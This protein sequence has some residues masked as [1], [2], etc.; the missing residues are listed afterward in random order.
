MTTLRDEPEKQ[1]IDLRTRLLEF[2]ARYYSANVMRLVLLGRESLDDLQALAI[3]FF[4]AIENKAVDPPQH[5]KDPFTPAELGKRLDVVPVKESRSIELS[6][7][8]PSIRDKYRTSPQSILSHLLGHEGPGSILSLLKARGWA[9]GLSAGPS[10]AQEAFCI[11]SVSVDCTDE[12]IANSEGVISVVYQYLARLKAE[13]VQPW[14]FEEC[15]DIAAMNF[16]FKSKSKP[17][18]YTTAIATNMQALPAD[19]TLAGYALFFDFSIED[20]NALSSA[21]TPENML[22]TVVSKACEG[23][24]DQEEQWY[25]TKYKLADLSAELQT[26]WRHPEAIDPMLQLPAKNAFIPTDFAL[27]SP[28][29]TGPMAEPALIHRDDQLLVWFKHDNTFSKPK[30]N[31]LAQLQTPAVNDSPEAMA[32]TMLYMDMVD[33]ELN[34]YAYAADIAGLH[35]QVSAIREGVELLVFG[36]NHKLINLL[37]RVVETLA[38]PALSLP[39]FNRIKERKIKGLRN[40]S[41]SQPYQQAMRNQ[42]LCQESPR[43]SV[44]D[45]LAALEEVSLED[46]R[47]F[48]PQVLRRALLEVLVHGNATPAEALAGA[49]V[50][51]STIASARPFQGHACG[52]MRVRVVEFPLG[53]EGCVYR[54]QAL[55]PAEKNS[56]IEVT[57]QISDQ[58]PPGGF[59]VSARLQLL[60]HLVKEPCF[61][62]LRTKEQLGYIV[63]SGIVASVGRVLNAR[64]IVQSEVMDPK[65]LDDRIEAFLVFFRD[66][67]ETMSDEEFATNRQ[68]VVD[69]HLEKPKNLNEETNEIWP[70]IQLGRYEFGWLP[71]RAEVVKTLSKADIL[72]FFDQYIGVEAAQRRKLSVQIF[73]SIFP[74]PD[75][76]AIQAG[77]AEVL[78]DPAVFKASHP[79]LP[80]PPIPALRTVSLASDVQAAAADAGG[81]SSSDKPPVAPGEDDAPGDAKSSD[82]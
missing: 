29:A 10:D 58:D 59:D 9:N 47:Y 41:Y 7:L 24:T 55:N 52:A 31:F 80:L 48:G 8:L 81:T 45:R 15:R 19:L 28:P 14:V 44:E 4:A 25:G 30:A 26:Q 63:F 18:Q 35:F 61:N 72:A 49:Q 53:P 1:G 40:L 69:R 51:A 17:M 74:L 34:E 20:I 67:L 36:Y 11:F 60:M 75:Q 82:N 56:A 78:E 23:T 32:K 64:F 21:L 16:R 76:G 73:G 27:R 57:F 66:F 6:W 68:A 5:P 43:W 38:S 46:L 71:K 2:H 39:V 54:R 22:V 65:G 50:V 13:G 70:E 42:V 79:L 77:D 3:R 62:E 12:G 37:T 33:E